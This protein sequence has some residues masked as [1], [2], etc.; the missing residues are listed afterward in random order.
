MDISPKSVIVV[1]A[2]FSWALAGLIELQSTKW[3]RGEKSTF[4]PDWATVAFFSNGLGLLLFSQRGALPPVLAIYA[5]NILILLAYSLLYLALENLRKERPSWLMAAIPPATIVILF[6]II[7][8]AEGAVR[9]R[10]LIYTIASFAAFGIVSLSALYS[11]G[12]GRKRGPLL[13]VTAFGVLMAVQCLRAV[14]VS[15]QAKV[16]LFASAQHLVYHSVVAGV[17]ACIAVAYL[18][19][20]RKSIAEHED[21]ENGARLNPDDTLA[22]QV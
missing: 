13:I 20:M 9:E 21:A 7:G 1:S 15:D 8:F 18:D 4:L 19:M 3:R 22:R 6:P 2:L 5:A 12:P 10:V 14:R 16:D 17:I 11:L